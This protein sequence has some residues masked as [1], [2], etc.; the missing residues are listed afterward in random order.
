[1]YFRII[2]AIIDLISADFSKLEIL[3]KFH[4]EIFFNCFKIVNMHKENNNT[5][6]F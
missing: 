6:E 3:W 5:T 2:I 4:C 1:M